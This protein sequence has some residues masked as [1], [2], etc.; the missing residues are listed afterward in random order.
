MSHCVPNVLVM[1]LATVEALSGDELVV[2][3][4]HIDRS[5]PS[6]TEILGRLLILFG[7]P[8]S[9]EQPADTVW[10]RRTTETVLTDNIGNI[11]KSNV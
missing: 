2:S 3:Q 11:Q 5:N 8:R 10:R 4:S 9:G 6:K 1:K 7:V